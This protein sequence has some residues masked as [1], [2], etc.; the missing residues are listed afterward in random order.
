MKALE[1]VR[2]RR[3]GDR[4]AG[5][6]DPEPYP[7]LFDPDHQPDPTAPAII[8]PR[9]LEQVL[10]DDRRVAFLAH[11]PQVRR[12]VVLHGQPEIFRQRAQ[13]V[14]RRFDQRT[15]ID[16]RKLELQP[17]RIQPR[18]QQQILDQAGKPVGLVNQGRHRG[19]LLG[20]QILLR[21]Q[22]L[23]SR[24][25]DRHRRLQLMRSIRGE[26]RRALEFHARHL[27]CRLRLRPPR[28][29]H[30]GILRELFHRRRQPRGHHV[31]ARQAQHEQE[32]ARAQHLP[33]H[34]PLPRLQVEQRV[35]ARLEG[36]RVSGVRIHAL[37]EQQVRH[38]RK[39]N[40]HRRRRGAVHL[41]GQSCRH[42]RRE[43]LPEQPAVLPDPALHPRA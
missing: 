12:K 2:L 19:A 8:L 18:Q 35:H 5:V 22:L 42:G 34:A 30:L 29:I 24:A 33:A 7:T 20:R 3:R 23:E 25:Q 9:V 6:A 17:A 4:P 14:Q 39:L 27:Q 41:T 28:P 38:T 16:R 10:Q 37:G 21:Q 26:A 1:D 11:D 32:Q 31:A 43:R 13:V 36:R 40:A 15:Q